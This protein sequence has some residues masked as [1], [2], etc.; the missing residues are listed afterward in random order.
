[1]I[2]QVVIM[3]ERSYIHEYRNFTAFETKQMSHY[4]MTQLGTTK[5]KKIEVRKWEEE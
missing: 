3:D 5:C 1:M 2:F 4:I